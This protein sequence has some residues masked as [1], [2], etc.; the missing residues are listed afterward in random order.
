MHYFFDWR[1]GGQSVN[2]TENNVQ[3]LHKP[4]GLRVSCQ[5]TRSLQ[6]NRI[7]AR[8]WLLEKVR[9]MFA[10]YKQHVNWARIEAR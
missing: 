1:K 10:W 8:K 7:I 6:Q 4:S 3:L 2:K 5:E 9:P